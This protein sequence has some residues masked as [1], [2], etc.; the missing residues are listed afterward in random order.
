MTDGTIWFKICSSMKLFE[1]KSNFDVPSM[2]QKENQEH[3][4]LIMIIEWIASFY[5]IRA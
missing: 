1:A 3:C 2:R 5:E 4:C